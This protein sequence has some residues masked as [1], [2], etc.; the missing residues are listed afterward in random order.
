MARSDVLPFPDALHRSL[1]RDKAAWLASGR[2]ST[3]LLA[4]KIGRPRLESA[5]VLDVGCGT[6][7]VKALIDDGWPVARYVGIDVSRDVIDWLQA[8]VHDPRFEFH[9]IN[10]RNDRYNPAGMPLNE[11]ERLPAG[12]EPY[13]VICLFSVFTHLAPDDFLAML[14]LLRPHLKTDGKL[15]FSLFLA[16]HSATGSLARQLEQSLQSDDPEVV[17]R[18]EDA[19]AAAMTGPTPGFVDEM[20][21]TPLLQARY[22]RQYALHLVEESG[23][24]TVDEIAPPNEHIQHSMVCSPRS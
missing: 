15:V 21:D 9:H 18:T 4:T 8:H 20:P 13:D 5:R 16:D 19:I 22:T 10:A 12:T 11:I 3:E 1:Y 2:Y 14:R 23:G 24:W 17:R 6:K 7:I